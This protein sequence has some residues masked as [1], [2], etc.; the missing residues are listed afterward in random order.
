MFHLV[1]GFGGREWPTLFE[2]N[3]WVDP[4]NGTGAAILV[5]II[6]FGQD[7]TI[8][9]RPFFGYTPPMS[10]TAFLLILFSALTHSFWNLLVKRSGDK[11]VFIW[12]MFVASGGLFTVLLPFLPGP[13]PIPSSR[14]LLLAVAGGACFVLY[15]LFTGR[16][17]R[18]G[19][20][21]VTYPLSQT[22]MLYVPIWGLWLLGE[23]LSLLGLAGILLV[24][25][26]AWCVQL[27]ELSLAEALR[28]LH[29]LGDRSVQAALFAGFIYSVGAVLDKTGVMA[30][31]PLYFTYLLVVCMF[32][33]MSANLLRSRY[34]G[35]VRAEWQRSRPLILL[36]GPVM[37]TSFLTFRYG[38]QLAPMSYAVPVRQVSL[39]F[40]VL[41]GVFLLGES[42]GRIRFFAASLVLAGVFLIRLG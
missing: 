42:C 37:M 30:Y 34:R 5:W 15:H 39:L 2:L 14:I 25:L 11:T 3:N 28:P 8:A 18:S 19:D 40:G 24:A 17:Y 29:R 6:Y 32:L 26:G 23:R 41:I 20:L 9:K 16:A 4:V 1:A 33:L 13:V 22:S 36:S 35:R 7:F 38:L 12:W 27:R 31:S 21:S 10:T